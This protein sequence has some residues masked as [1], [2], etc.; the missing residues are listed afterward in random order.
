M[1]QEQ[2]SEKSESALQIARN[3]ISFL[4]NEVKRLRE[5][6]HALVLNV[7]KHEKLVYG[8][9]TEVAPRGTLRKALTPARL[10]SSTPTRSSSPAVTPS[11]ILT[12]PSP[13]RPSPTAVPSRQ[14]RS[15][16]KGP[17]THTA[18]EAYSVLE[19]SREP[20]SH[21]ASESFANALSMLRPKAGVKRTGHQKEPKLRKRKVSGTFGTSKTGRL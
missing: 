16:A 6:N 17:L 5:D 2:G 1:V 13:A 15:V 8:R 20:A 19:S 10:Q 11:R 12:A 9:P 4:E 21:E 3:E 18:I 7:Q 14:V